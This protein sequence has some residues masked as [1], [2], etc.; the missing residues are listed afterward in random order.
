MNLYDIPPNSPHAHGEPIYYRKADDSYRWANGDDASGWLKWQGGPSGE[1][2]LWED[3]PQ[4]H[5]S[6]GVA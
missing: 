6:T 5:P 3:R 1:F 2:P 4:P